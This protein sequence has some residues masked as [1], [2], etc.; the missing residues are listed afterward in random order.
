MWLWA[1]GEEGGGREREYREKLGIGSERSDAA[2]IGRG[3]TLQQRLGAVKVPLFRP[4]KVRVVYEGVGV[5]R[6]ALGRALEETVGGVCECSHGI[7]Q[8]EYFACTGGGN[9]SPSAT[10]TPKLSYYDEW[11]GGERRGTYVPQ[12]FPGKFR[13]IIESLGVVRACLHSPSQH[14]VFF[15]YHS[16][17][18]RVNLLVIV[19]LPSFD[20]SVDAVVVAFFSLVT[21]P[22]TRI[23]SRI[24]QARTK[25]GAPAKKSVLLLNDSAAL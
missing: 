23:I 14:L 5:V 1:E 10:S 12:G 2:W 21:L 16:F 6:V 7:R 9:L 25:F 24:L 8:M 20:A 18:L 22:F 3:G 13:E 11:R 4:E 15:L 17:V 19:V